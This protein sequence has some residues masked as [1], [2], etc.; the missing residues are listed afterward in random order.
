MGPQAWTW[1]NLDRAESELRVSLLQWG[2]R[3]GPGETSV[4]M[5]KQMGIETRFNG[6]PGMDLG[7][8]HINEM[9]EHYGAELQWGP[10]HG[11]GETPAAERT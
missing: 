3:H 1:G 5:G 8:Q 10:R 6:A 4:T 9:A 7:K 11:P 2:P